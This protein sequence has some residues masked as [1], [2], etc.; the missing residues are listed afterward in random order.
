VIPIFNW[1]F[2]SFFFL[3]Q[4]RNARFIRFIHTVR[5][6]RSTFK[7]VSHASEKHLGHFFKFHAIFYISFL[8]L[9]LW[10][11]I[12]YKQTLDGVWQPS[13]VRFFDLLWHC[14]G[15]RKKNKVLAINYWWWDCRAITSHTL[16]LH[17]V[18]PVQYVQSLS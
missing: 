7:K 1:L 9:L 3:L 14:F 11:F 5:W 10:K 16:L 2:F 6:F 17:I 15:H 4:W 18:I 12:S 13:I 8:I